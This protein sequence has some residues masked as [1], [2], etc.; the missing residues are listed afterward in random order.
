MKIE[1]LNQKKEIEE[2]EEKKIEKNW[3]KI[4]KN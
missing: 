3:E 4:S 1:K 2:I